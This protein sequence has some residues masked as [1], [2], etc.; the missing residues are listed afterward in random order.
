MNVQEI[1][2]EVKKFGAALAVFDGKLKATPPGVLPNYL[3]TAI[4]ERAPEIKAALLAAPSPD[5][6]EIS[7]ARRA[8]QDQ[9]NPFSTLPI[10]LG[11]IADAI[12]AHP[13]SPLLNDLAIAK[14]TQATLRAA[15]AL[16]H[17]PVAIR[18]EALEFCRDVE[19]RIVNSIAAV[20]YQSAYELLAVLDHLPDRIAGIRP[21]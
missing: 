21:Q 5:A 9:D 12:A 7:D 17:L 11:R 15:A 8:E 2:L 18:S 16:A 3:K 13:R 10:S 1:L 19:N 20:N 6:T 14:V 4:R